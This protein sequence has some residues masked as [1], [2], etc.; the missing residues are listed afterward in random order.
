MPSCVIS[1]SDT[2]NNWRRPVSGLV[3]QPPAKKTTGAI[4]SNL[5]QTMSVN[6]FMAQ[7][8]Q[9]LPSATSGVLPD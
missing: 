4:T 6:R 1:D 2:S 5:A 3:T 9:N 7:R 8:E